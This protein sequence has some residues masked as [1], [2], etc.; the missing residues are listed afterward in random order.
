MLTNS[1]T[2]DLF[3]QAMD[4]WFKEL[5]DVFVAQLVIRYPMTT[6]YWTGWPSQENPYGFP[7]SWQ[8]EFLK[9]ILRLEPAT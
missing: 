4:V 8:Q 6:K 9:T 2:L 7:H 1:K 5:P 3:T